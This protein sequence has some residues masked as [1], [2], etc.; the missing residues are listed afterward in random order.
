MD[1]GRTA[2]E[3]NDSALYDTVCDLSATKPKPKRVFR[4]IISQLIRTL[5]AARLQNS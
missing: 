1:G 5:Q 3:K 2:D 4:M